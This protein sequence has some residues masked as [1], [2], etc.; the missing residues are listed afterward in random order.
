[1]KTWRLY[2]PV[3]AGQVYGDS[4]TTPTQCFTCSSV[5]ISDIIQCDNDAVGWR[6]IDRGDALD[7]DFGF[8]D[9]VADNTWRELD[10]S[11]V[12]P[13][14]AANKMVMLYI[15]YK[16][17]SATGGM[18][19]LREKGNNYER[20]IKVMRILVTNI[21]HYRTSE[22]VM[23]D[24]DRKIEYCLGSNHLTHLSITVLGWMI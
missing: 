1:M 7:Y 19:K 8:G 20:N 3:C 12:V 10:L 22:M 4:E 6:F 16:H 15:H 23:L 2:C 21:T 17:T 18:L 14:E 24:S 5:D 9:F 11:S 13:I